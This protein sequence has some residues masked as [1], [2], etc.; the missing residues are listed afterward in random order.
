MIKKLSKRIFFLIMISLET[1]VLGIIIL[2][3]VLNYRNTINTAG[4]MMD[5]FV[6]GEKRGDIDEKPEEERI[7]IVK[8]ENDKISSNINI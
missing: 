4:I 6:N 8:S 5:I 1:I 2:F 3:A 7:N